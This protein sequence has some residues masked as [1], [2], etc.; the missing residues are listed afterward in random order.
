MLQ[1]WFN[2]RAERRV[3]TTSSR[4]QIFE[5]ISSTNKWGSEESVSG[6]GSELARTE[7]IRAWFPTLLERFDVRSM[8]D[9]PC[10]DL[11]WLGDLQL[12]PTYIGADIVPLLVQRNQQQY[13]NLEFKVMDACRDP[14]PDVD[15]IL[16]RDLLVH[17]CFEDIELVVT[18][19]CNSGATYLACTTY[20]EI[21]ENIDKLTG[22]HRR[23]NMLRPPFRWPT[24]EHVFDEQ[25]RHGK[26]LGIWRI[27]T[28]HS[29][30]NQS[31]TRQEN[32]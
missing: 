9:L 17:L 25:E 8:L 27:E 18:N 1:R 7:A 11:N 5:W 19:I 29:S 31:A 22:K 2:K 4:A 24:P 10:G 32:Q 28:L 6:K 3:L 12:P 30:N 13:P 21:E 20:P 16:M 14:M 15:M 23:L 26:A